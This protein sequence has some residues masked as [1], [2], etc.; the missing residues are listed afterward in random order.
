MIVLDRV[1]GIERYRFVLRSPPTS[2]KSGDVAYT[3]TRDLLDIRIGPAASSGRLIDRDGACTV[4]NVSS[5]WTNFEFRTLI[6]LTK[7]ASTSTKNIVVPEK[8]DPFAVPRI[9]ASPLPIDCVR[10]QA[11]RLCL[12]HSLIIGVNIITRLDPTHNKLT[13]AW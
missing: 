8:K 10:L 4:W 5:W 1:T 3:I 9:I 11:W 7:G 13:G 6:F 2:F 12:S